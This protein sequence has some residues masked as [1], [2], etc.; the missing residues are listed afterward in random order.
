MLK[1]AGI[2]V[3]VAAAGLVSVSPLAFATG[4]HDHGHG[5]HDHH[6]ASH[7]VTYT[8]VERDNLTNDCAFGQAGPAV[9]STATGGSSL[10]GVANLVTSAIAPITTQTQLLNCT[11]VNVSDV[12]DLGSNNE[13][14]TS[15][16]T[17]VEGSFNEEFSG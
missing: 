16:R 1:K 11:N 14:R 3:A 4:D 8:N 5:H 17:E 2:V 15:Q 9:E 12:I 13:S 6:S 10:L 7:D